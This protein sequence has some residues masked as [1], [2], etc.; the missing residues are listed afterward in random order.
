LHFEVAQAF[1]GPPRTDPAPDDR[2]LLLRLLP[3][4]S[5]RMTLRGVPR[6][7]GITID[8]SARN[9]AGR[10]GKATRVRTR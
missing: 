2:A 8:V 1:I 3:A 6:K 5:T 10:A 9:T 4:R 7:G